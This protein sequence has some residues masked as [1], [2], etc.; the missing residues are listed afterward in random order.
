MQNNELPLQGHQ[1]TKL[2]HASPIVHPP[3]IQGVIT[4]MLPVEAFV[5]GIK[6]ESSKSI[7][8]SFKS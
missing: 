3:S 6:M 2:T 5:T 7:N 4:Y 1:F 8:V